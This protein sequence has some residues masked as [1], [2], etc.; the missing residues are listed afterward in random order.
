[1]SGW[2][3]TEVATLLRK[4][5]AAIILVPLAVIIIAFAVA[6]RQEVVI[7][8]DPFDTVQPGYSQATWLFV[9]IFAA[10]IVGVLIGGLAS[11]LRQGKWRGAAR[12]FERELQMLRGK[13]AAFEDMAGGASD[14]PQAR[15]P[16][17]RLRLK[18][19]VR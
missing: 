7:S 18:P 3:Q 15:N 11:W 19:P 5:I 16:P 10:L 8:F 14:I 4:I 13:L 1:M 17:E 6:N 12:R 9:P 2:T